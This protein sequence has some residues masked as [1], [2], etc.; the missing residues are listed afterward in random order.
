MRCSWKPTMADCQWNDDWKLDLT[1]DPE[2]VTCR[3]CMNLM[4]SAC[5][6]H[7]EYIEFFNAHPDLKIKYV[8]D[9]K[10]GP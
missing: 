8:D 10:V 1:N 2:E 3:H 5:R 7:G 4:G 9:I 6:M